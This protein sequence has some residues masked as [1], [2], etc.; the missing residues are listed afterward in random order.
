M[1]AGNWIFG[2]FLTDHFPVS[3]QKY[4]PESDLRASR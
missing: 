4:E 2:A 3:V 1:R